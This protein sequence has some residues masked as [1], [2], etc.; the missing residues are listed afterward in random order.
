[1]CFQNLI[2]VRHCYGSPEQTTQTLTL[3][4]AFVFVACLLATVGGGWRTPLNP[5]QRTFKYN[6]ASENGDL[7]WVL[8]LDQE[9]RSLSPR[10]DQKDHLGQYHPRTHVHTCKYITSDKLLQT[11][12]CIYDSVVVLRKLWGAPDRTKCRFLHNVA[13]NITVYQVK[14]ITNAKR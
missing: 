5:T 6:V 12:D 9:V 4:R 8:P 7:Y 11:T 2:R 10:S 13:L 1:M 14:I 3:E